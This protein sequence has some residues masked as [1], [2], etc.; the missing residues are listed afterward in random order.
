MSLSHYGE[1]FRVEAREHI[2]TVNHLLLTLE[3]EPSAREPVEGLFRAVHT[4]KGMSATM[5]YR[6]VADLSHEMESV[7]DLLRSGRTVADPALVDLLFE[8]AD[9]LERGIEDAVRERGEST[10]SGRLVSLLRAAG[11]GV[12]PVAMRGLVADPAA[13]P[14]AADSGGE[15][16]RV[17]VTISAAA[18]LPGVRAFMV[19]RRARELGEVDELS[20]G[21]GALLEERFDGT[22]SLLLRT[23]RPAAEVRERLHAVGE[24]EHL[25]VAPLQS[26]SPAIT[27]AAGAHP[28]STDPVQPQLAEMQVAGLDRHMRVDRERLDAL[29]DRVGELVI[30]RDRLRRVAAARGGD[31]LLEP[32]EQVSQLIGEL[33]AD[34]LQIRMVPV[35]QVFDRFPRLVRDASRTLGKKVDLEVEGR[36]IELDRALLDHLGDPLVHLLRNAIDH[37][38]ETPAERIAA[39]K[40][41]R[42]LLRLTASRERTRVLIRVEDDG[43]GIDRER[44]LRKAVAEGMISADASATLS[45][46]EVFLL[47]MRSGFSTAAS[48]TD[49]SGR[50]VGL[51]VVSLRVRALGGTLDIASEPGRGTTFTLRLPLTVGIIRAVLVGLD[52]ETYAVPV[53][54]VAETV[55]LLPEEVQLAAGRRVG[56]IRDE[57]VP[58][59]R[60]RDILEIRGSSAPRDCLPV[61]VLEIGEQWVGI[62]VDAV[63]GQQEVVLKPFD[64]TNC[65]LPIFSGATVLPDGRPALILDAASLLRHECARVDS[66]EPLSASSPSAARS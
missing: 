64:A 7:L 19:L 3:S 9:A 38:I 35:A 33:S 10:D 46:A 1:L 26:T 54:H 30:L 61:L 62:E 37:G 5:G 39:G 34:V 65:T 29:M 32:V 51:D 13:E 27:A 25:D 8:A 66:P 21:E 36:G 50:G 4:V 22:M 52:G 63:L 58:L 55:E 24:L 45:D 53:V 31:D 18:P 56:I 47:L 59:A 17:H 12:A 14:H 60:L 2:S 57:P 23:A 6:A 43:R 42:G 28:G 15:G 40:P 44:V 20:P 11:G 48:V 16:L 49:V 41:E